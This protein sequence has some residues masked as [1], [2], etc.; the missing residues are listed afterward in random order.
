LLCSLVLVGLGSCRSA[1]H[2][3]VAREFVPL[4]DV[5]GDTVEIEATLADTGAP[6]WT[7]L[8]GGADQLDDLFAARATR[9]AATTVV[10]L[11]VV[12][13]L[14]RAAARARALEAALEADGP[15][16]LDETGADAR[17]LRGA[18]R[19]VTLVVLDR[20]RNIVSSEPVSAA[21]MEGAQP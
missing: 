7:L 5:F 2:L 8:I 3:S 11:S 10:D 12:D 19:E 17:V 16:L 1:G 15:L 6:P 18:S 13:D 4:E 9:P 20:E 21:A 14:Q